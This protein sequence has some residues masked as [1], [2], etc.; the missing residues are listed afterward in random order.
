MGRSSSGDA[1]EDDPDEAVVVLAVS[2]GS[3]TAEELARVAVT[4]D[5]AGLRIPG[6]IVADPDILDRTTG[7]LLRSERT[8]QLSLPTHLTGVPGR[9][10]APT[11]RRRP[12]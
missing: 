8:R 6:M 12:G 7:R 5:D 9:V 4:A 11:V 3:A 10:P 1:W 2:S